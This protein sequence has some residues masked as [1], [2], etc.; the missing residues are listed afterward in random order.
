MRYYLSSR[1]ALSAAPLTILAMP[2]VASA[3]VAATDEETQQQT[4]RITVTAT[5]TPVLQEEAPATVTVITD[6]E[7]ADQLATDIKDLVRFEPGVSVRRAPADSARRSVP[8][9]APATRIS[10]CAGSAAT[11]C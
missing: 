2:A 8:P 4:G 9:A 3:T 11:G 1:F 10:P 6:Q 7:I 5:R